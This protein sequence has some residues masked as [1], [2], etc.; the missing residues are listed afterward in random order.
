MVK[1]ESQRRERSASGA[2]E[3]AR[4]LDRGAEAGRADHRA[5]AAGQ[6]ALGHLVPARMLEVGEQQVADAGRSRIVRPMV[7]AVRATTAS[8]AA[9]MSSGC[10]ARCGEAGEHRARRRRCRPRPE[11]DRLAGVDEFGQR[12]VEARFGAFGP[13]FIETQKQVP[14]ALPQLTATMKAPSRRAL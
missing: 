8:A 1:Q 6:A 13:V 11:S 3:V 5:V 12:E 4:V 14:P 2:G 9:S 7:A 10:A